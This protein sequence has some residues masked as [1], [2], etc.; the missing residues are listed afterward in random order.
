MGAVAFG[1]A[2]I[3]AGDPKPPFDCRGNSR[4]RLASPRLGAE[5]RKV[6]GAAPAIRRAA[7]ALFI[8]PRTLSAGSTPGGAGS[9]AEGRHGRFALAAPHRHQLGGRRNFAA[10]FSMAAASSAA[11]IVPDGF[12]RW[13]RLTWSRRRNGAVP[14]TDGVKSERSR[15]ML[16]LRI[17]KGRPMNHYAES[18]CFWK[19]QACALW[20]ATATSPAK[21]RSSV[22]RSP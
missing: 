14:Q 12:A 8:R 11:A 13:G 19:L 9:F 7:A 2:I 22:K 17:I 21:A 3:Q 5:Q 15:A 10:A 16:A 6:G 4:R 18:T 20:M 1:R